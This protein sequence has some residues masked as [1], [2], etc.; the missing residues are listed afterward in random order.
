MSPAD[1]FPVVGETLT[2]DCTLH[3]AR[4][5]NRFNASHLRFVSYTPSAVNGMRNWSADGVQTVV[6]ENTLRLTLHDVT[7][8]DTGTFYCKLDEGKPSLTHIS[9]GTIVVGG[10][11]NRYPFP[12]VENLIG[13]SWTGLCIPPPLLHLVAHL[14]LHFQIAILSIFF[15]HLGLLK[16]LSLISWH[17]QQSLLDSYCP[18]MLQP[19]ILSPENEVRLKFCWME[20]VFCLRYLLVFCLRYLLVLTRH[21]LLFQRSLRLVIWSVSLTTMKIWTVPFVQTSIPRMSSLSIP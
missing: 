17:C 9:A 3:P 13:V 19:L 5:D 11:G 18:N 21:G 1:S 8:D 6:D 20:G 15:S 14:L 12:S 16:W 4:F 7:F 10:K 2:V